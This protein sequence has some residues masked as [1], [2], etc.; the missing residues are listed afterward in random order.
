MRKGQ[1]CRKG[2]GGG[3]FEICVAGAVLG[4]DERWGHYAGCQRA[5]GALRGTRSIVE[6]TA[7][8]AGEWRVH[9]AECGRAAGAV[10]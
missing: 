2:G 6:G 1:I 3:E 8:S 7:R 10:H 5:A 4:A 9:C